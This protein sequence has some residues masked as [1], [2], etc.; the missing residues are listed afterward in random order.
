MSVTE[1]LDQLVKYYETFLRQC[2]AALAA[3]VTQEE[4]DKVINAIE[5]FL[6]RDKQ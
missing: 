3:D 5:Q 4:R 2:Q 1:K 6:N